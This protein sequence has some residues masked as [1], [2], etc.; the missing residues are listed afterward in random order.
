MQKTVVEAYIEFRGQLIIAVSGLPGCGK[1]ALAKNI[2]KLFKLKLIDQ[3]DYFKLNYDKKIDIKLNMENED[4]NISVI[5]WYT[6]DAIDWHQ[7]NRDLDMYKMNGIVMCGFAFPKDKIISKIDYHIHLNIN[8]QVCLDR[9]AK[10]PDPKSIKDIPDKVLMNKLIYPYYLDIK[11]RSNFD[12]N[13]NIT[14]MTD[15]NVFDVI[16]D[17]LIKYIQNWLKN[18]NSVEK[19]KGI[20]I[21]A[22]LD[23]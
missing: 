11:E 13:L 22:N 1:L 15:N 4:K 6:D 8:K 5:N 18:R 12:Y 9:R 10:N 2:S 3:N 19:C 17:V 21:E 23:K 20:K 14:D 7:L 16:F